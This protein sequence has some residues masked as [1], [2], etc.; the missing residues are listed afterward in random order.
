MAILRYRLYDIDILIRRTLIYGAL[1][2]GLGLAY[3]ATVILLQQVLRPFLEGS[4]LA[5]IGSTLAV[6][7]LFS[8]ARRGIQ[9]LVDRRFYRRKYDSARALEDFGVSLRQQIDLDTL[10]AELLGVVQRTVQPARLTVWLRPPQDH[11]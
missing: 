1:T 8:P 6:A 10:R 9:N 5:V 4:E 11:P 7:A 3:W 2:A